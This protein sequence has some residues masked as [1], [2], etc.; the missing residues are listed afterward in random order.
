MHLVDHEI[1]A[2]RE[3]GAVVIEP[4]HEDQL[5]PQS[6]DLT[7]GPWYWRY[8][9]TRDDKIDLANPR[10]AFSGPYDARHLG[11]LICVCPGE[12]ILG[13]TNERVGGT[14]ASEPVM[15]MFPLPHGKVTT[16]RTC[17][18]V[19]ISTTS[20]AARIGI[21]AHPSAG[22]G[23]PGFVNRWTLEI[24]NDSPFDIHLPVGAIIVQALFSECAVPEHLYNEREG[25][26]RYQDG[27]WKPEHMLPRPLKVRDSGCERLT[28]CD[29][30]G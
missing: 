7:L 27:D 28:E 9:V 12:R 8:G 18:N 29:E 24:S 14:V 1:R 16:H 10:T 30:D 6:Y 2:M 25:S 19:D 13:H 15:E 23:D 3:L 22:H 4:F 11:D 26:G 5:M 21:S 20:T 17:C